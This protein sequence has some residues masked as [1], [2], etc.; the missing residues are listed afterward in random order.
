MRS[1][2]DLVATNLH[3]SYTGVSATAAAVIKS[4]AGR[5]RMLLA[6]RALPGCM[7]PV[8][9][10]RAFRF[11]RSPAPGR[12]FVLWHVRRNNEIR[13]A[14]LARNILKLPVRI[15][16]TSAAQRRHSAVPRWLISQADAVIATTEEAAA[17]VPNVHAI[18]HHGVDAERFRPAENRAA[19]WKLGQYP[20]K[21]GIATI[22]RVR[23]EKGTDLFVEAMIR[24]LPHYPDATA[25]IVGKVTASQRR[26]QSELKRQID[27]AGLTKRIIFTGEIASGQLPQ[28]VRSLSLLIAAARYE[29]YGMTPLEAMA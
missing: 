6:G 12:K 24:L 22:G 21:F 15:I 25:L 11:S 26:F 28:L 5:Y 3:R 1:G 4:Q 2:I 9:L 20:G 13:A 17:F 14:L 18:V 27:A 16:F 8:P 23:P 29:G 10:R 19:A 7:P